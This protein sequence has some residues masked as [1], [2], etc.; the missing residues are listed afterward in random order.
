MRNV[1]FEQD[2]RKVKKLVEGHNFD[3]L[4]MFVIFMDA[5]IMGV[6]TLPISPDLRLALIILEK[7]FMAL[8]IV[9]MMMKLYAYNRSFF[10]SG[11]NVFDLTVVAISS[12]SL[13]FS[14]FI[15][16][17]V[18]RLF[19]LLKY[20]GRFSRLKQLINTFLLLLP[21]FMAMLAVFLVFFYVFAVMAVNL[22]GEDIVEFS[23]LGGSML[24]LLQVFTLDG[25]SSTIVRP[26]MNIF[27]YAW[28]F[29]V[30]FIFFSFLIVVSFLMSV[31]SEIVDK[32][33]SPKSRL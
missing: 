6:S 28:M 14:Y 30:S 7:G 26:M 21:N 20:V 33:F 2:K 4:I 16:L 22:Y 25:W 32:K 3:A 8:F 23:T 31:V 10:K 12:L 11:W 5:V 15:I 17:R 19:R 1:L 27:P 9:E 29:F 13:A 24:I 18:F